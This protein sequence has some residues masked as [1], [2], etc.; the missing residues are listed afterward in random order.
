MRG[1]HRWGIWGPRKGYCPAYI[2][3]GKGQFAQRLWL[4]SHHK[5]E[6]VANRLRM[7]DEVVAR[8]SR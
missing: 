3:T 6:V 5:T 8:I 1:Y 2:S 4:R 7:P